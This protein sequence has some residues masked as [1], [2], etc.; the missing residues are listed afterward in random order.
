MS[1]ITIFDGVTGIIGVSEG[2]GITKISGVSN[3]RA[4]I[5]ANTAFTNNYF[6]DNALLNRYYTDDA[7]ANKYFTDGP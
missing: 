4:S 2:D 1:S 6:T 7:K 5:A 3:K